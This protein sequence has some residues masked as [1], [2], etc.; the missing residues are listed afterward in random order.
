MIICMMFG[1]KDGKLDPDA[2]DEVAAYRKSD[3]VH[4]LRVKKGQVLVRL[5]N[6][7]PAEYWDSVEIGDTVISSSELIDAMDAQ[8]TAGS[9]GGRDAK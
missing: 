8:K 4:V 2:V 6:G 9:K 5:E 7:E 3:V 1:R